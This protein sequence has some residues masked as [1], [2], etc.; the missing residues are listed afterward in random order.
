MTYAE[1]LKDPR[2]QK[3]RLEILQRDEWG[4]QHCGD[5]TSTLHVHHFWYEGEPWD[6]PDEALLSLCERCHEAEGG[7]V[8]EERRLLMLAKKH[9]PSLESL[10]SINDGLE[11]APYKTTREGLEPLE[12]LLRCPEAMHSLWRLYFYF[13]DSHGKQ[14]FIPSIHGQ[15]QDDYL[16][17]LEILNSTH[18]MLGIEDSVDEVWNGPSAD[19]QT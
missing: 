18:Q 6:A 7:R 8:L 12:W 5:E 10:Q 13:L 16:W 11:S 4:C 3:R 17:T 9:F 14:P 15:E 1:K 19:D 2:W